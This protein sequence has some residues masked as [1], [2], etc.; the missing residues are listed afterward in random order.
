MTNFLS[1]AEQ[2]VVADLKG[3]WNTLTADA[4]A[5]V[6]KVI[7]DELGVNAKHPVLYTAGCMFAGALVL[8]LFRLLIGHA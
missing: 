2:K 1:S 8:E 5:E 4:K 7:K 3:V 6:A